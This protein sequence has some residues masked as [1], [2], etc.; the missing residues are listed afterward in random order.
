MQ[1]SCTFDTNKC[2]YPC[3]I[4]LCGKDSLRDVHQ[5]NSVRTEKNMQEVYEAMMETRDKKDV[6][7][8]SKQW[9]LHPILVSVQIIQCFLRWIWYF[10]YGTLTILV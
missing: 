8:L 6:A 1:V 4:C 9:S 10:Q 2:Q 3:S 7:A 5:K